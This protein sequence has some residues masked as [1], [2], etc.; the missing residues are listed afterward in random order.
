MQRHSIQDRAKVQANLRKRWYDWR[1]WVLDAGNAA[2]TGMS[3]HAQ[4]C[5][6][7]RQTR[8]GLV[9]GDVGNQAGASIFAWL[10]WICDRGEWCSLLS[11]TSFFH[12]QG[13][14][15]A[16][17]PWTQAEIWY[18]PNETTWSWQHTELRFEYNCSQKWED[19][20]KILSISHQC[21]LLCSTSQPIISHWLFQRRKRTLKSSWREKDWW[22]TNRTRR[23][24]ATANDLPGRGYS[25]IKCSYDVTEDCGR[26]IWP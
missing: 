11:R 21:H 18:I 15:E 9:Q 3:F 26:R 24:D 23:E 13:F 5:V 19:D 16:I 8:P 20:W 22:Q 17:L 7:D 4:T 14:P 2:V 1:N 12:I 6:P 10:R 25:G